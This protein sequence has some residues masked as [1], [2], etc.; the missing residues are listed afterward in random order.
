MSELDQ[1]EQESAR[2]ESTVTAPFPPSSNLPEVQSPPLPV[3]S[4]VTLL[5]QSRRESS[6]PKSQNQSLAY[7]NLDKV[8]EELNWYD[9]NPCA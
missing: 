6:L 4:F 9:N 5:G 7:A 2:Q 8:D 1:V 3:I